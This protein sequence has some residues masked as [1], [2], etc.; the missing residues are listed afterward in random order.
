MIN[1]YAVFYLEF[2]KKRCL[3]LLNDFEIDSH[4]KILGF[5]KGMR[6]QFHMHCGLCSGAKYLLCDEVFDGLDPVIRQSVKGVIGN[7]M[8]DRGLTPVIAS[9]NLRELEDI[10]DG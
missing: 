8:L 5:S 4:T 10:C 6:K 2:D 7:D 1:F 3:S 9:H